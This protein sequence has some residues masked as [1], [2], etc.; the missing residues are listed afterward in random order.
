MISQLSELTFRADLYRA[1]DSKNR[2]RF[3]KLNSG[4]VG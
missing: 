4:F 1:D 2:F 3:R